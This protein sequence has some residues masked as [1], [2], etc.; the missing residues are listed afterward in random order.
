MARGFERHG[1]PRIISLV[2]P[3]NEPSKRVASRIHTYVR[4]GLRRGVPHL[5]FGT[6]RGGGAGDLRRATKG[7]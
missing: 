3:D 5:G 6:E 2:H 1:F 4:D 7:G